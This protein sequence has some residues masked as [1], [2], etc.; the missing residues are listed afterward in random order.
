MKSFVLIAALTALAF[1]SRA[2]FGTATVFPLVA[3]DTLN[4]TDTVFKKFTTTAGYR[5]IGIHVG[6][7]KIS[8]TVAGKVILWGSMDGVTYFATDSMS[9]I[10]TTP[11]SFATPAYDNQ[12]W[13]AKSGA[14]F[15]SYVVAATSSGT[16]SAQVTVR[17]TLR[18]TSSVIVQ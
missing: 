2:Q 12:A 13:V 9:Y 5:D 16:V 4:N 18:K 7:K 1:T 8:G 3:G 15:T 11:S 10:V 14:P 17:Y 6:I